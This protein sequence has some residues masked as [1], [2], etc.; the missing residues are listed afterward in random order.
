VTINRDLSLEVVVDDTGTALPV[1]LNWLE[2]RGM[3]IESAGEYNPPFDDVFV[4]L[5]EKESVGEERIQS[6]A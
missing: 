6:Y 4:M 5:L 3:T 2:G 1:L